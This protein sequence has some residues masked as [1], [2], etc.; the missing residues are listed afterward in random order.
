MKYFIYAIIAVVALAVVAGF[1]VV[2]SP[3]QERLRR[4]DAERVQDLQNLQSRIVNF[5]QSK[6][7]LPRELSELNDSLSG[8]AVPTDPVSGQAY[9]Y[10][11]KG[12]L[13]FQLCATFD[14]PSLPSGKA[15]NRIPEP[16]AYPAPPHIQGE[17][18]EHGMGRVCFDRTIDKDLYKLDKPLSR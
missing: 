11:V 14:L 2:G 1:F 15:G 9:E 16:S 5:W 3:K 10:L 8:F 6:N 13:S 12:E 7:Q 17:N 4:F 18:W